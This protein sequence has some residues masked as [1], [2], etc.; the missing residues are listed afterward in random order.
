MARLGFLVKSDLSAS[1]FKCQDQVRT[2][3][4]HPNLFSL[5]SRPSRNV[6]PMSPQN[7][8]TPNVKIK[9]EPSYSTQTYSLCLSRSSLN[10]YSVSPRFGLCRSV[11]TSSRIILSFLVLFLFCCFCMCSC[12]RVRVML[13][14]WSGNHMRQ[15]TRFFIYSFIHVV[16]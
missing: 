12:T 3:L 2:F 9:F 7:W 8:P 1:H 11:K 10:L 15:I 4:L 5:L 14:L 16:M 6:Y 13:I